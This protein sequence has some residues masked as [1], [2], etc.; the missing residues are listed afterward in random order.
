MERPYKTSD[1]GLAA[2]LLTAGLELLGCVESGEHGRLFFIF[3]DNT[4][5]ENLTEAWITGR[6][7][8][9]AKLYFSK[10]RVCKRLLKEPVQRE[11]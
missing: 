3:K 7:Q 9:S 10:L 4:E 6:D 1:L 11:G 8:V 2:Y 5:R